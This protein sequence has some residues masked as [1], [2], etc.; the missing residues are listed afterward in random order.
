VLPDVTDVAG[1]EAVEGAD[2]RDVPA[3][4]EAGG[5][6]HYLGDQRAAHGD[7]ICALAEAQ[8][9]VGLLGYI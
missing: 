9:A 6:E 2:V 3:G 1:V 7:L 4:G 5:V 8:G